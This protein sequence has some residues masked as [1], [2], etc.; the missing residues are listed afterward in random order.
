M[1]RRTLTDA[2]RDLKRAV[3]EARVRTRKIGQHILDTGD[4]TLHPA[5]VAARNLEQVARRA[6]NAERRRGHADQQ[7]PQHNARARNARDSL[8]GRQERGI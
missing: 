8:I 2:E 7:R 6:F 1:L 4:M 5:Y 3:W